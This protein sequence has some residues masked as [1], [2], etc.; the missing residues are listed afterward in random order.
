MRRLIRRSLAKKIIA[1]IW[2]V[3]ALLFIPWAYYFRLSQAP[4]GIIN[5][6]EFWPSVTADR[7][8]FLGVVTLLVYT[9]PLIF[10]AYCYCS[11][12]FRVW[13][14]V[15]K[16][17]TTTTTTGTTTVTATSTATNSDES[18]I[19]TKVPHTR[20]S[21][22]P[23]HPPLEPIQGGGGA[24]ETSRY[25][26]NQHTEAKRVDSYATLRKTLVK[27]YVRIFLATNVKEGGKKR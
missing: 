2:I 12:I 15:H 6:R 27:M 16:A 19:I 13:M 26:G 24:S 11:I 4:D 14:R 7:A 1:I 21:P 8:Y 23:M 25:V 5:C 17:Q 9:T 18:R 20:Y 22:P 3:S 10:M